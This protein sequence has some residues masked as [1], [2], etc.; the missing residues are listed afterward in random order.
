MAKVV[1]IIKLIGT[2]DNFVHYLLYGKHI[3]RTKGKLDLHKMRTAPQYEETRKNQSEFAVATKAGQLFRHGLMDITKGYTDCNYP[4]EV[5]KIMLK[6]LR[7]DTTQPKGRKLIYNGLKNAEAQRNFN[8]LTIFSKRECVSYKGNLIRRTPDHKAWRLNRNMLYGR[9]I[10]GDQMSIKIGFYHVDF[11]ARVSKY[12]EV[13][14]IACH[15]KENI[16]FSDF[17]LPK[18]DR[19][20]TPWTFVIMQVWRD[21]SIQEPTGLTFMSV[22]DVVDNAAVASSLP[23][24]QLMFKCG[25]E[26][27]E[28]PKKTK[29]NITEK[30]KRSKNEVTFF[31]VTH[32][33]GSQREALVQFGTHDWE[34]T[35]RNVIETKKK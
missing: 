27:E 10:D 16:E 11:E 22:L 25:L 32:G 17:T 23:E 35:I 4:V 33:Y 13:L 3:C 31:N 14:S 15:R 9:G 2:V 24:K 8:N 18:P 6:T 12:E 7:S 29:L 34:D 21:G 5:M 19:S 1:G 30:Q 20:N 28:D 26:I